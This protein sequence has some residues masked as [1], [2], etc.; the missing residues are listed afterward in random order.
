MAPRPELPWKG[1]HLVSDDRPHP[2]SRDTVRALITDHKQRLL[3]VH[4][5]VRPHGYLP[6]GRRKRNESPRAGCTRE[7]YEETGLVITAGQLLV[8]DWQ[9]DRDRW[10]LL[11]DGGVVD[12]SQP[13]VLNDDEIVA[14]QW[15][16]RADA[17]TV[18]TPAM[19]RRLTA[20]WAGLQLATI[21]LESPA[22]L[23]P[24]S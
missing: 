11:F 12:S 18:V 5:K 7:V 24:A 6:G 8:A 3:V 13:L 19:R 20:W 1:D 22:S 23:E 2:D 4:D 15:I 16:S 10:S 21:Y 9:S 14:A 17:L